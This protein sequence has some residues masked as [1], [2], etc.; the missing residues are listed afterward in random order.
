VSER[1]LIALVSCA[2]SSQAFAEPGALAT[3]P[4][5][6]WGSSP[7]VGSYDPPAVAGRAHRGVTLELAASAGTTSLDASTGGGGFAIG[8]W[9]TREVAL[10][11]RV[12]ELGAFGFAGMSAQYY[13]TPRL[14]GGAGLGGLSERGMDEYGGISRTDGPGGFLRAGYNLARGGAH[15]LYVSGELQGGAV[16]QET[17]VVGLIAIGY[18][19]L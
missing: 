7:Y 13:A 9:V 12:T 5:S 2:L 16:E 1:W 11:F 18:Q 14:W 15:A 8:G 19:L 10:A 17:R 6:P 4:A 3:A